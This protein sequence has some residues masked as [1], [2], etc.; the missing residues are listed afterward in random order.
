ML[1][2]VPR[3][4]DAIACVQ[5]QAAA[6]AVARPEELSL[7]NFRKGFCTLLDSVLTHRASD[8]PSSVAAFRK[9]IETWSG[10]SLEPVS[11]GLRVLPAIAQL[12]AGAEPAK[13]PELEQELTAALNQPFCSAAIMPTST[14]EALVRVGRLWTVWIAEQQHRLADAGRLVE[15]TTDAGWNAWIRG[16]SALE[17]SR[18]W[19]AVA[20]LQ[21]ATRAWSEQE[22]FVRPGV[23]MIL[24]P[25]PELTRAYTEL[26]L[27]RFL[28]GDYPG[29]IA[30]LDTS[31]KRQPSDARAIFLRARAKES[32]GNMPE[33][34]AD[35][36]LASRTA[37]AEGAAGSGNAHL[38]RGVALFRRG[39]YERAE[40][41]FS[42][43]LNFAPP[44]DVRRDAAAWRFLTA[45]KR[46][47]CHDS[48][49]QLETALASVSRLFPKKEAEQLIHACQAA[50]SMI[51]QK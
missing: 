21:Q 31:I 35:Y 36:Q 1:P 25:E 42:S 7:L 12:K 6:L 10:R 39:D 47:E 19:E 26:G 30:S 9:A 17:G 11:S 5:S 29:A 14:C 20:A 28:A 48:A 24:A 15:T 38:Y 4:E 33:A 16:Q 22:R 41:E 45:V 50:S 43:A 18:N 13:L 49:K 32:A 40:D 3:V 37:F 8:A 46:G 44:D 51:S 23:E 34:I 27:A 2:A